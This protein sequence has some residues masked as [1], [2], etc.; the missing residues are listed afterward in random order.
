MN[1]LRV[2]SA[3]S[4]IFAH[5]TWAAANVYRVCKKT[6]SK[7][8]DAIKGKHKY[9][10]DIYKGEEQLEVKEKLS[11]QQMLDVINTMEVFP[12]IVV[13]IKVHNYKGYTILN[14]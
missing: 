10:I 11:R 9:D 7:A 2:A 6:G 14:V 12:D 3:V 4:K 13:I 5:T 1:K 8:V